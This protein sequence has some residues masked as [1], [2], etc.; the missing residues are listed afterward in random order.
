MKVARIECFSLP[1]SPGAPEENAIVRVTTDD[2][3]AGIGETDSLP[4]VIRAIVDAPRKS[5]TQGG[6]AAVLLGRDPSDP[7][8]LWDEM[9]AATSFLGRRGIVLHAMSALDMALWDIAAQA[10]GMPVHALLGGSRRNRVRAYA[11][12]YPLGKSPDSACR[13]IDAVLA[14][15]R[16]PVTALKLSAEAHWG[17]EPEKVQALAA[18]VRRH[19]G[20]DIELMFDAFEGFTSVGV[21]AET[22]P[23]LVEAGF[24]WLEA[25]LPVD[26]MEGHSALAGRGIPIAAGDTGITAPAEWRPWL[27]HTGVDIMQPDIGWAGG[28]TGVMRVAAMTAVR[29]RRTIPH[30]WNTTITLAANLH[31]HAALAADEPAEFSSS[32]L[33]LRWGATR[34]AIVVEA[35][36]TMAVPDS[37]GLGVTLTEGLLP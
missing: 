15:P 28:F 20:P 17:E 5:A 27:D 2:G 31:I 26:D 12:V 24:R 7:A 33:P 9:Y 22:I 18:R 14:D 25:P 13:A 29:G 11:T 8:A 1:R 35:D 32:P 16:F 3:L 23:A 34:E 36:G 30:G 4:S 37:P 10:A 21:A 19:V 6:L